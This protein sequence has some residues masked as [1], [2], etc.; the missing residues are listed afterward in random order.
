MNQTLLSKE[1]VMILD[2]LERV[3]KK[4]NTLI[5]ESKKQDFIREIQLENFSSEKRRFLVKLL[6][7]NT[8]LKLACKEERIIA[9]YV[10][11]RFFQTKTLDITKEKF[12]RNTEMT[13]EVFQGKSPNIPDEQL[14]Q[15][16]IA[17]FQQKL[18][19]ITQLKEK[20]KIDKGEVAN[21][22]FKAKTSE[23]MSVI[24]KELSTLLYETNIRLSN[25]GLMYNYII[26]KLF[27]LVDN[28]KPAYQAEAMDWTTTYEEK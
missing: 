11:E 20:I 12:P 26:S 24:L 28:G 16:K 18:G 14:L 25:S 21:E 8:E 13:S 7:Q 1:D 23:R 5:E 2:L 15:Q 22:L 10:M 4:G 6:V 27:K 3:K 19:R 9:N 17:T